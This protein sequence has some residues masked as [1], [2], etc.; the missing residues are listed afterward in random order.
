MIATLEKKS[1]R[2]GKIVA[3]PAALKALEES[4]QSPM[5]FLNRHKKGD[6][7]EVC[8]EDWALNDEALKNDTRIL[9]AYKTAKKQKLWVITEADRSATTILLPDEY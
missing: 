8:G 1:F 7:G 6:W 2:L 4:H 3:T 5:E 9:S